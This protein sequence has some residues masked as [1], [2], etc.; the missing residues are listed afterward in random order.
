VKDGIRHRGWRRRL[1]TAGDLSSGD[2]NQNEGHAGN[3][4][5]KLERL[6]YG[7]SLERLTYGVSPE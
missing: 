7:V 6:T 2:R 3:V 4:A 5:Q 1:L